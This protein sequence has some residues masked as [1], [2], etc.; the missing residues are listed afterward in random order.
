MALN[1][2][3]NIF[4]NMKKGKEGSLDFGKRKIQKV[5]H[6]YTVIIPKALAKAIRLKHGDS[7]RFALMGKRL[8]V[9]QKEGDEQ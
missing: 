6:S 2:P 3:L 7:V 4:F 8:I 1:N 9:L 5:R